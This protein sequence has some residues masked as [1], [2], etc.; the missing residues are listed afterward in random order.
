MKKGS[1]MTEEQ[2]KRLS[3]SHKGKTPWITGKKHSP[4]SILK[5]REAH[6]GKMIGEKN[7]FYGK[8]HSEE[9]KEKNRL[10]HLGKSPW[11]TG[12]N[13]KDYPQLSHSGVK[14]GSIPWNK[15]KSPIEETLKKMSIH[16]KK[17]WQNPEYRKHMSEVH[18]GKLGFWKGKHLSPEAIRKMVELRKKRGNYKWTQEQKSKLEEIWKNIEYRNRQTLSHSGEKSSFW[19]GGAF[20]NL[21][22]TK[23]TRALKRLI[24]ERDNYTCQLCGKESKMG[25]SVHHI[26]YNKENCNEENL[27]TLCKSCHSKT[28]KP[29]EKWM[30]FFQGDKLTFNK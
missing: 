11:N 27:I 7:P 22:P 9:S 2:R 20:T 29:R 15:G 6:K 24:R 10:A 30:K 18:K 25:L 4:E 13:K 8:V 1:K 12:K 28:G 14:K 17:I 23:W 21:Y 16:S 19:R 5:M 3:D 26:D